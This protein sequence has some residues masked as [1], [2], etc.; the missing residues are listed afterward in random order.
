MNLKVV[1]AKNSTKL[2]SKSGVPA[3][4]LSRLTL[5]R[6]QES[7]RALGQYKLMDGDRLIRRFNNFREFQYY[8]DRVLQGQDKFIKV[9]KGNNVSDPC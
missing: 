6:T 9:E 7:E 4:S 8:S 5:L 3:E 1:T 2:G